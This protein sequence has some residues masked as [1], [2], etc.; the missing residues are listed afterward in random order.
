M[1]PQE[2]RANDEEDE[3]KYTPHSTS[4]VLRGNNCS[5]EDDYAVP[6]FQR[7]QH[8][9]RQFWVN[10]RK[11]TEYYEGMLGP[12]PIQ[13]IRPKSQQNLHKL[14]RCMGRV[15]YGN[16]DLISV[17]ATYWK[18]LNEMQKSKTSQRCCKYEMAVDSEGV[19]LDRSL[20]L[21][22]KDSYSCPGSY[23]RQTFAK[24]PCEDSTSSIKAV[25]AGQFGRVFQAYDCRTSQRFAEK[26]IDMERFS[27]NELEILSSITHQNIV[28]LYGVTRTTDGIHL[29]MQFACGGNIDQ[30]LQEEGFVPSN[31]CKNKIYAEFWAMYY[32]KQVMSAIVHLHQNR[33]V[34]C[35][36]KASNVVLSSD[37]L[38]CFL[39]DFGE[40]RRI[41]ENDCIQLDFQVGTETNISPEVIEKQVYYFASDVWSCGCFLLNMLTGRPPWMLLYP[42][43]GTY[44]YVITKRPFGI[45]KEI[46]DWTQK[47][48]KSILCSSFHERESRKD[49]T[50]LFQLAQRNLSMLYNLKTE[51]SSSLDNAQLAGL[52]QQGMSGNENC[53][54]DS[55]VTIAHD[56]EPL[57]TATASDNDVLAVFSSNHSA[58]QSVDETD[59]G[60]EEVIEELAHLLCGLDC[61]GNLNTTSN[62]ADATAELIRL[63]DEV[64]A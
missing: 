29:F 10:R 9:Q 47:L 60:K 1:K 50:E 20:Y 52:C 26:V 45:L 3:F 33:I 46:P 18:D 62:N 38:R 30:L 2:D 55:D 23:K 43:A 59:A 7:S 56:V 34:H 17:L 49:A 58:M 28:K 27:K 24:R 54:T 15:I 31:N 6:L 64:L 51:S 11:A 14:Q 22:Q 16:A 12:R 19:I 42:N 35:D 5:S 40:A 36:I 32:Y 13:L 61:K 37:R 48:T 8:A 25:G 53:I 4:S 44:L 57:P 63:V 41:T 39:T 21:S